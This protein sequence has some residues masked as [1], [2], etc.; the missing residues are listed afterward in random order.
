MYGGGNAKKRNV[1]ISRHELP[2]HHPD[3]APTTGLESN[4]I[5]VA[6]PAKV[7]KAVEQHLSQLDQTGAPLRCASRVDLEALNKVVRLLLI[8]KSLMW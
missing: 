2:R 3:Y 7:C 4:A 6:I 1:V 5:E 8:V